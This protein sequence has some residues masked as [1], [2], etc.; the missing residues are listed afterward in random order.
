MLSEAELR[1]DQ[2]GAQYRMNNEGVTNVLVQKCNQKCGKEG[3][4]NRS[5]YAWT[6]LS[7]RNFI[8]DFHEQYHQN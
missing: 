1:A 2:D 8:A 3:Y 4:M 6:I 5:F 7:K